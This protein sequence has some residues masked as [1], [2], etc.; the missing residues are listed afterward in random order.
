[1][2]F[3]SLN[4]Y[5]QDFDTLTKIQL[6]NYQDCLSSKTAAKSS[7]DYILSIP[8]DFD[9][10]NRPK[11]SNFLIQ[12][13]SFCLKTGIEI[14]KEI[15]ETIELNPDLMTV[16][17]ACIA[18]SIPLD[19]NEKVPFDSIKPSAIDYYVDYCQNFTSDNRDVFKIIENIQKSSDKKGAVHMVKIAPN[20]TDDNGLKQG[21]WKEYLPDE[22]FEFALINYVDDIREG[23]FSAYYKSNA[24]F[25][26]GNYKNGELHG[27]HIIFYPC[28]QIK[29]KRYFIN[30]LQTGTKY[31]YNEDGSV[32]SIVNF[33]NDKL[34]G[35][36]YKYD[37]NGK[38][39]WLVEYEN[40]E[41]I[42]ITK[43]N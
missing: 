11:I 28:G 2:I 37:D 1:M 24:L 36:Y 6:T 20:K 40:G 16:Y 25:M 35:P 17:F 32:Y 31:T 7:A 38:L 26:S 8:L 14:D 15:S 29:I 39:K 19:L 18:K 9:K 30:G 33:K 13:T 43:M 34:H 3:I 22:S 5:G 27:E 12:W 10:Q 23:E 4:A 41:Q 21:L 42:K